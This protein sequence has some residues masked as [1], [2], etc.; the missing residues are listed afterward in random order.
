LLYRILADVI[1]G[2]HFAFILYAVLGALLVLRWRRTA[3]VH[4]PVV[5]WGVLIELVGW[6]CPLTP[7][8]NQLR[9]RAG[10]EG[11]HASFIEH[12]VL[13]LVYPT[14][15]TREVQVLLAGFVLVMNVVLYGV[16]IAR[17]LRRRDR[18]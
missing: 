9:V 2:L 6:I 1:V 13:P 18:G 16:I 4:V 7:L 17:T 14:S 11:Y 10:Q 5:I 12:Y 8:E 3:W 15:L